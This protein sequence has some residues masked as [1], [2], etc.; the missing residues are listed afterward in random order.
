MRWR[1]RVARMEE[2][3]LG[4]RRGG[5]KY[6]EEEQGE[7]EFRETRDS[8]GTEEDAKGR[9]HWRQRTGLAH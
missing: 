5:A 6:R 1:G 2:V 3:N 8:W 7:M 4:R 9:R